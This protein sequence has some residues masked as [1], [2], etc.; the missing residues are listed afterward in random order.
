V[1]ASVATPGMAQAVAE[2]EW[3]LGASAGFASLRAAGRSWP[4]AQAGLELQRGF[5][6]GWSLGLAGDLSLHRV[7]ASGTEGARTS[8]AAGLAATVVY[9]LDVLR[10]VP[11]AEAGVAL[12]VLGGD[13]VE[14]RGHLGLE[15]GLGAE[16]L[17]DRRWAVALIARLRHAPLELGGGDAPVDVGDPRRAWIGL[18]LG[19]TF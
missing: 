10:V 16:W 15:L 14:R 11:L 4:G 17:L 18:R 3:Q 12:V 8:S 1:L 5:T 6:G 7:P 9:A 13:G 19:R 2:E